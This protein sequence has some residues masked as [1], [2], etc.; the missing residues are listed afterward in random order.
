[1]KPEEI[2]QLSD[3]ELL[4]FA[5]QNKPKPLL[6]AFLIGF[7]FGIIL[8]GLFAKAW[9]FLFLL[10]LFLINV[11]LKKPRQQA[12]LAKELEKRNLKSG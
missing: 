9:G 6:D 12:A 5:E 1:M 11:L 4:T 2:S 10:P 7:L 8:F 3:E